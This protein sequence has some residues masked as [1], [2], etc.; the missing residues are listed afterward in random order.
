M[1]KKKRLLF[2]GLI[3][4]AGSACVTP[5]HASS[6]SPVVLTYI[7]ASGAG[8]A[9]DELI[10][11]HNNS[12]VEVDVTNWCL[13]N[14]QAVQFACFEPP[15]SEPGMAGTK[16]FL[17]AYTSA[18][19]AS[20]EHIT[21]S[22]LAQDFFS[23][24]YTATNQT[25]GSLIASADTISIID[26]DSEVVDVHTW[27]SAAPSGKA[28]Q[29]VQIM[30]SPNIYAAMNDT[31]DWLV[32]ARKEAP[33]SELELRVNKETDDE[34]APIRQ[35]PVITEL[36][37]NASGVDL[38]KEFIE[39]F[40]PG[41]D[42][43]PLDA[44]KLRIGFDTP[45]WYTFPAGSTLEPNQYKAFFDSDM[46]FTLPNTTGK[47]QL[48]LGDEAAGEPIEYASPK[49]D[50]AWA[51]I[52]AIWQYTPS[53]TPG[54]EN[55]LELALAMTD[56]EEGETETVQELK[57]CA[58]NQYRNPETGRCKLLSVAKSL[59]PTP[60]KSNQERNPET[61]RCRLIASA[62][63]KIPAPCKEGQERN[64]ETNRCRNSI[65]MSSAQY[66]VK[67]AKTSKDNQPSWY[68]FAGIG[69][70]VVGVLAYAVWEW[71]EELCTIYG[72]IKALFAKRSA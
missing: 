41:T 72:R 49:D 66:G 43:L 56:E 3:V 38:G 59:E 62:T 64:P 13:V 48:F 55:K 23:L 12:A 44:F 1:L 10:V 25:S 7:Q 35:P 47:V 51:F 70:V 52:D 32:D 33:P 36:L 2:L 22:G 67:G 60:C 16:Y 18:A 20:N 19:V 37:A 39:L 31:S 17:P 46:G 28:Y 71:R 68:Y 5:T 53:A 8:G 42:T 26:D 40:N 30:T 54:L 11:I 69:L 9:K 29:R 27:S 45:K 65:K 58:E 57:P 63:S 6:A 15:A 4:L 50:H 21:A 61:G 34:A 24:T 14:K